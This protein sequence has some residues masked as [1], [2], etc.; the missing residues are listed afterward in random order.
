MKKK[1]HIKIGPLGE[2]VACNHLK[3]MG[4]SIIDRNYRK[5][6]GEIDIIAKKDG[7]LH[8][9]EVKTV[10]REA[11][12]GIDPA[13]NIH[14]RKMQKFGRAVQGYLFDHKTSG[15]WQIDALLIVLN[16]EKQTAKVQM[17]EL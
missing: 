2:S 3:S 1:E 10:S 11:K 17:I 13:D 9:V 16:L 12:D 4:F 5:A 8:F 6:F 14:E 7:T 15:R